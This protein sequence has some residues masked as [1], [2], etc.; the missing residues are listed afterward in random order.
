M[1]QNIKYSRPLSIKG[2]KADGHTS[3]A[4]TCGWIQLLSVTPSIASILRPS[5]PFSLNQLK[6]GNRGQGWKRAT[7]VSFI[8]F[9]SRPNWVDEKSKP[10]QCSFSLCDFQTQNQHDWGV[11]TKKVQMPVSDE[12]SIVEQFTKNELGCDAYAHEMEAQGRIHPVGTKRGLH[13][14][15]NQSVP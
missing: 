6:K 5:F 8:L 12:A 7:V 3:G 10:C 15:K 9:L 11:A 13:G 1:A 14:F 2:R 4:F